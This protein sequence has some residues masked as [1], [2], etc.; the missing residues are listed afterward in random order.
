MGYD[1]SQPRL[2]EA[3]NQLDR[4]AWEARRICASLLS[5]IQVGNV[6]YYRF[7]EFLATLYTVR[8]TMESAAAVPGLA[9]YAKD[10][11]NAQAY[12]V[13]TEYQAMRAAVIAVGSWIRTGLNGVV[14]LVT[15]GA[16]WVPVPAEFTPAQTA[17]L[18]PLLQA[19][20]DTIVVG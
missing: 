7:S 20:V 13:V 2:E 6:N 3:L 8:Q 14:S 9:Q 10:Q 19:A 5:D 12:D 11:R 4:A 16:D 15:Y 18:A 17:A 1:I